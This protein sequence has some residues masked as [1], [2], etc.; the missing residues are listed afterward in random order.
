VGQVGRYVFFL[1]YERAFLRGKHMK[2]II[3][4]TVFICAYSLAVAKVPAADKI[5]PTTL[6][7]C[8]KLDRYFLESPG[9][10]HQ[11]I[12]GYQAKLKKIRNDNYSCLAIGIL[13]FGLASPKN[14]YEDGAAQNE[15][16]YTGKFLAKE[17]NNPM[18]LIYNGMG[19]ALFARDYST[20]MIQLVYEANIAVGICDRAVKFAAGKPYEWNIRFIRANYYVNLPEFFGKKDIAAADY[21]FIE[22]V[23]NSDTN[24]RYVEGA[25]GVAYYY[26]GEIEKYDTNIDK[27]VE[28]W[29][30]SVTINTIYS[31]N[32]YEA[33]MAKKRLETF[34]DD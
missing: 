24:N 13:Y 33:G 1:Q 2:R 9:N 18:A 16:D 15:I 30:K 31:N 19:H 29:K 6:D 4:T 20:N 28:Y 3:F 23:Y 21:R 7:D 26:L 32:N 17:K 11:K 27:A 12:A 10:I 34:T 25:M 14:N 5:L 22:N 8:L